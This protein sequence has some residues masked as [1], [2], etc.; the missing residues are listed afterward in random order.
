MIWN[1]Y[2]SMCTNF[3][4]D[5]SIFGS[6]IFRKSM[7]K[8]YVYDDSHLKNHPPLEIECTGRA[9]TQETTLLWKVITW[10]H[11]KDPSPC[12]TNYEEREVSTT[13]NAFSSTQMQDGR[14]TGQWVPNTVNLLQW[15]PWKRIWI[16]DLTTIKSQMHKP[17]IWRKGA[18]LTI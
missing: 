2:V 13:T 18:K 15:R 6:S 16:R 7:T 17:W 1:I 14:K 5:I 12:L 3:H 10:K 4:E 11:G 9:H 8:L